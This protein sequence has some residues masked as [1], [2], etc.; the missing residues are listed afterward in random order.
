MRS[1]GVGIYLTRRRG[2]A[3]RFFIAL[4]STPTTKPFMARFMPC[5]ALAR[6]SGLGSSAMC[7]DLSAKR[8]VGALHPDEAS[9]PGRKRYEDVHVVG[10]RETAFGDALYANLARKIVKSAEEFRCLVAGKSLRK[11]HIFRELVLNT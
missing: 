7:G 3:D 9:L 11:C 5:F 6:S 8:L 1:S 4:R 10:E 2:Y